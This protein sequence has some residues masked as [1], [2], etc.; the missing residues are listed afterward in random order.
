MKNPKGG[1]DEHF[2][3]NQRGGGHSNLF[4]QCQFESIQNKCAHSTGR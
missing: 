1:T 2:G 4:G 3:R